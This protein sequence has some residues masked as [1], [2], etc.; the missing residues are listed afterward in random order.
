MYVGIQ[1]AP[2]DDSDYL[3]WAQLGVSHVC[4]DP[5]GK[6]APIGAST[7]SCGHKEHVE[8]FGLTLDMVQLPLS[9]RPIEQQDSPNILLAREPERLRQLD[10]ICALIER[11]AAPSIRAAKFHLH[12][13]GI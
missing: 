11:L 5:P 1:F 12:I 9:S 10:S 3:V 4:V 6:P 13:I 8:S 2:R 7:I